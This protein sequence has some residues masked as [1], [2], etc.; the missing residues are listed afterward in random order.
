MRLFR[1]S[2]FALFFV[3]LLALVGSAVAV[4]EQPVEEAAKTVVIDLTENVTE[5]A[6]TPVNGELPY[7]PFADLAPAPTFSCL[8]TGAGPCGTHRACCSNYCQIFGPTRWDT[9]CG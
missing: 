2:Q 8:P 1:S 4:A 7:Q 3:F 5:A 6:A 9:V